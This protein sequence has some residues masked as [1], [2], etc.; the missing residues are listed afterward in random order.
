MSCVLLPS[1]R[2]SAEHG[3]TLFRAACFWSIL[4]GT[5]VVMEGLPGLVKR[6]VEGNWLRTRLGHGVAT[7]LL[8]NRGHD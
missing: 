8:K 6:C 5:R 3:H 1:A 2:P 7:S 4:R